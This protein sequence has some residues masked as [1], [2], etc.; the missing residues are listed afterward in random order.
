MTPSFGY[1][2]FSP[3]V[4]VMSTTPKTECHA[5]QSYFCLELFWTFLEVSWL[6]K[7]PLASFLDVRHG[8]AVLWTK[9]ASVGSEPGHVDDLGC[10]KWRLRAWYLI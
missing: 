9:I 8:L 4:T 6:R 10:M 1:D 7:W 2:D 3:R 5:E